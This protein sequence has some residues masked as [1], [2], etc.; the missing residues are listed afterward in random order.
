MGNVSSCWRSVSHAAGQW[1]KQR[2]KQAG[3]TNAEE[4]VG[5]GQAAAKERGQPG[6][7]GTLK[8][9]KDKAARNEREGQRSVEE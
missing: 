2:R 3:Q 4:R 5:R 6:A 1:E 8:R 9:T 7:R